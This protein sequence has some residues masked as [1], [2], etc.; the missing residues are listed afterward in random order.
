MKRCFFFTVLSL[1]S[2][3]AVFGQVPTSI[4]PGALPGGMSGIGANI[5]PRPGSSPVDP[6]KEAE[7]L[8][9]QVALAD[10][11]VLDASALRLGENRAFI[12]A[13]AGALT[14]K[15]DQKN[16][17]ALFQKA[18]NELS[19]A[20]SMAEAEG[21]GKQNS[22]M[23]ENRLLQGVRAPLLS[24]IATSD[25][26]LA[27]DGMYRTRSTS[28]QRALAVDPT[29]KIS[30]TNGTNAS[31]ARNEMALE[32]RLMML[33]ADKNPEKAIKMLQESLKKGV[34]NE[35]L[36]L[37]KK[38][39]AK[40]PESATSM[41][42]DVMSQLQGANFTNDPG[43]FE[44]VNAASMILQDSLRPPGKPGAKEFRFDDAQ[45]RSLAQKLVNF[46]LTQDYRMNPGRFNQIMPIAERYAPG[47]VAAL[48]K[49]QSNGMPASQRAQMDPDV[50]KMMSDPKLTA[51]DMLQQAKTMSADVRP[52]VYQN[53]A[54]KLAQ[55]GDLNAAIQLLNTSF[56]G[57]ALESAINS[58]NYTYANALIG[59]GKYAE[60]EQVID[61]FTDPNNKRNAMINLA[62]RAFQKNPT[63]NR[64]L[65]TAVLNKVRGLLPD[66]PTENNELNQFMQLIAAFGPIDPDQAFSTYESLI[67]QLN[68]LADANAVVQGFQG[69]FGNVR[70]GEFVIQQYGG[71]FGFNLEPNAFR[72]LAKADFERTQKLIDGFSRREIRALLRLQLAE[73]GLQ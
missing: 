37:L 67:P 48:K 23:I 45:L 7:K 15:S 65:A 21:R 32:Q 16:G 28:I 62:T 38:L 17:G 13:R 12:Y 19:N 25:P 29:G 20:L 53:A 24:T 33:A 11:S 60:A 9:R 57:A 43:D 36:S 73:N 18:I 68:E 2:T 22:A 14:W 58:V 64:S 52:A 63:E 54:A 50:R 44:V 70:S 55:T 30:D 40:D 35:T 56:S 51:A 8:E 61:T 10:A 26:E 6:K 66:R 71:G 34:S 59:Q 4:P 5:V 72:I 47:S 39:Y 27:L 41:A 3:C 69:G 31:L 49:V 42:A 1:M 46:T